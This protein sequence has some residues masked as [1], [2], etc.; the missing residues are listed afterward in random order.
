LKKIWVFWKQ[1]LAILKRQSSEVPSSVKLIS[2]FHSFLKVQNKTECHVIP[3]RSKPVADGMI[4]FLRKMIQRHFHGKGIIS[5]TG[6][7]CNTDSQYQ[8]HVAA[9]LLM[10][11]SFH[12][13]D[14]TLTYNFKNM[15]VAVTHCLSR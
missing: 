11:S 3:F 12:S 8:P 13:T 5:I 15:K 4:G 10:N 6:T 14:Q 7:S 2:H 1:K 9:D